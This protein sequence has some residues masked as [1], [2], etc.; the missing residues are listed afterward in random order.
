MAKRV[1]RGVRNHNPGNID[2]VAG[3]RWQGQ[4]ADQSGDPRFVVFDHPKF[5]IRAVAR[6][7]VT[8]QDKRKAADGSRIDTIRE[9][10]ERWAPAKENDTGAYVGQVAKKLGVDGDETIDVYRYEVMR[11]LVEAI[12]AHECAGYRYP[13]AVVREGLRLAGIEPPAAPVVA[14]GTGKAAVGTGTAGTAGA[15]LLWA[16]SIWKD[17]PEAVERIV[18]L[19]LPAVVLLCAGVAGFFLVQRWRERRSTGT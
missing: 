11:P 9:I 17:N 18:A 19:G 12:I 4:S 7:L 15:G 2:R 1:P 14:T 8:Y 13:D 16:L 3:V 5:G 10:I 6:V